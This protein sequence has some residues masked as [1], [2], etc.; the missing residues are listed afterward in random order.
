V[1]DE[2][3][4]Q[5]QVAMLLFLENNS[6]KLLSLTLLLVSLPYSGISIAQNCDPSVTADATNSHYTINS[7]GTVL[8]KKTN[9]VWMRCALGQ[10]WANNACTDVPKL[11]QWDTALE[12]AKTMTFA[13][14]KT[15]RVPTQEELQSLIEKDCEDP[16]INITA[17]PNVPPSSVYWSSSPVTPISTGAWVVNFF[18]GDDYWSYKY[19]YEA[20]RL[21]SDNQPAPVAVPPADCSTLDADKDGVNDCKDKCPNSMAGSKVD[22]F[23][24]PISI[25]LKGVQF[26]L[27]SAVLTA[28]SKRILDKVAKDLLSYSDAKKGIEVQGHTSSEASFAHNLKLSQRRAQSVLDYLQQHGVK[29]SLIAKGYGENFPIADN[30]MEAGRVRN[31]RVELHWLGK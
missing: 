11:V 23:G 1:S 15:W 3:Q 8:D 25:E 22:E 4:M 9:L 16:A 12:T 24:C 19:D 7:N 13:G 18:D 31:R 20:V 2:V 21:V 5:A 30:K 26:E 29:D 28:D 14:I 10:A 17:F 27:D 6:M